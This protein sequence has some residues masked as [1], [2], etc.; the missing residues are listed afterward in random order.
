MPR[1][2]FLALEDIVQDDFPAGNEPAKATDCPYEH[3]VA[4][5]E[6][7]LEEYLLE[8]EQQDEALLQVVHALR[9]GNGGV[10]HADRHAQEVEVEVDDGEV[11]ENDI[12]RCFEPLREFYLVLSIDSIAQEPEDEPVIRNEEEH[13]DSH[14]DP[15]RYIY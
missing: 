12:A 10:A 7:Y 4:W 9:F 6:S 14:Q 11:A 13:R 15:V 1:A 2:F 5:Q 8:V 3:E